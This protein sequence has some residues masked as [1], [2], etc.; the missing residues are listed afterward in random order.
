VYLYVLLILVCTAAIFFIT[1]FTV[2]RIPGRLRIPVIGVV[3]VLLVSTLA[4]IVDL[5]HPYD[6]VTRVG[7]GFMVQAAEASTRDFQ[8]LWGHPQQACDSQGQPLS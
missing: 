6:G 3:T 4:V 5:S 8:L 7:P 2:H 1:A